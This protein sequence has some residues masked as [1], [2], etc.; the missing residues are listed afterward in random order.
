MKKNGILHPGLSRH[1][2]EMGHTDTLAIGDAGL[3]I[4]AC[5][6]R[7]DLALARGIPRF[8]ETLDVVLQEFQAE[9]M[10]LAEDL[11]KVSPGFYADL[12]T[13]LGD[14]P[15]TFVSHEAFKEK[16]AQCKAVVRTGEV[17]PYANII[18]CSGVSF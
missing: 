4:P 10:F 9:H 13:R 2:A 8:L 1:I 16:T 7:I 5:V 15:V 14:L 11:K 17:T 18:L 3:P 12:K 6:E